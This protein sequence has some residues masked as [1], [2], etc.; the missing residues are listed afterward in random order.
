MKLFSKKP[1]PGFVK[2]KRAFYETANDMYSTARGLRAT[3]E[4][5]L[6]ELE[7]FANGSGDD[8][9]VERASRAWNVAELLVAGLKDLEEKGG[10]LHSASCDLPNG[11]VV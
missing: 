5:L 6:A 11:E 4:M 9:S 1:A 8:L 3:A 2:E 10:E 7:T